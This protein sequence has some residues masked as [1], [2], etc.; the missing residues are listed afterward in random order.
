MI[1]SGVPRNTIFGP[2]L[3]R[4]DIND[5]ESQLTSSV[6]LLADNCVALYSPIYSESDSLILQ[7][8][9]F[10]F[11]KWA[12]TCQMTFN[13]NICKLLLITYRKSTVIKYVYNTYG[14]NA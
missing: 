11:K 2:L 7:E 12:Y 6:R 5:I 8:D 1:K 14:M 10:R 4:I 3:F 13:V 9:I